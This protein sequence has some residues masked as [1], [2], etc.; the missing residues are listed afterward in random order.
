L[1]RRERNDGGA[2]RSRAG[3]LLLALALSLGAA[4]SAQAQ[5]CSDFGG[6]IDGA[7][8]DVAP[9]QLQVDQNCTIRNFPASS[10]LDTNFSFFTQPGQ[11]P[12]RWL[13]VFDNVVHTGQMSCSSVLNHKIWFTNGSSSSIQEGCQNLLIPVEKIDKQNP[14]GRTTASIGVPFTYRLT[15]PVLFDAGTGTVINDNGSLNDLHGITL[16]DDLNATGA[17]LTYLD[18]VAYWKGSGAPVSHSFSNAGGLLTFGDFPIVPA[19]EQIVVEITVVL[20]DTPTNALGTQFVNTAKWE[21]GRL[22][23]GEFF[24]PLPGEWGVTPPL[25]IAAPALTVTKTGPA[26]L[27]RTLN[28]GEAGTFAIDVQNTGLSEAWDIT[29]LDRLPDGPTGGM[30]DLT[31]ELLSARVFEP[32]GTTPVSGELAPG[33]D[34][35]FAYEG[36]P[37]CELTLTMLTAAG[38]VGPGERL[39]VTY[40]TKLDPDTQDGVSLT[41]V[42]GA[43]RWFNGDDGNPDRQSF[44]RSLTDGTVGV[45]DHE[46]AHTVTA[47][48][49]GYFFEKSVENVTSGQSPA[50]TAA[51]GDTLRYTLRLQTTDVPLDDLIFQDDLGALNASAVFE[52]GTLSLVTVPPGADTS[53]TDPSGG[54]NG[55]G[56]LD[57]RGLS[58]SAQSEIVVQFDVTLDATLADGT[59]VLNQADLISTGKIADSDDPNINGQADPDV[60]GDEDPTRVVIDTTPAGPLL[61]ENTQSTAS[62]GEA[63][64]YRIT[65]PAVPQPFPLYDVRITDDLSTSAA[66]LQF[67]GVTKVSGSQPWTPVH[68]GTATSLVIEDPT[69][70]IDI[71]GGEQI[72]LEISV[73]LEDTPTNVAGLTF[74]NTASFLYNRFDGDPARPV[75]G[76][77]GTSEPMVIVEPEVLTMTKTGPAGMTVGTPET[78]TLDVHNQGS[79]RAWGLTITDRL[80]E[81]SAAGTCDTAPSQLTA[82]V[83][84]ADGVTPVSGPLVEDTDFTVQFTGEPECELTF[85]A[86]TAAASVGS[87]ERLLVTYDAELD[88]NSQNG[89][90]LTNVA[91]ATEWFGSD[92]SNPDT[93]DHRRV[94]TRT[95]TDGTV[96]VLDHEDAHTIESSLPAHAFEKTVVN[97]TTGEDP[98]N[99]AAPG[100]RLRYRL[101]IENGAAGPLEDL[102]LVDELDALNDP[103][104]FEPGTLTLVTVPAGADASN[105]SAT[106]GASGT[107]LVDIRGLDVPADGGSLVVE[108]EVTL[109]AVLTNGRSVA[110]QSRLLINGVD[111]VA[112]DDPNVNGAS[113]PFLEGD[114]DPTRILVESAPE[115]RIEKISTDRTGD[116]D[117]LLA[118]ETL[119]YTITVENVGNG[120]AIDAVLRDAV[121]VNT[122]YVAG[123]TTLNGSP[124]ADGPSGT[125]PLADGIPIASPGEAPGVVLAD[126]SAG[127]AGAATVEFDV[128]VDPGV[129]DGTVISNQ[130]FVSAPDGGI[131][132]RPSDDPGTEVPDDP[133]RD[134][135]G[136]S[137]LL[138]APKTVKILVD[139]GTP[140]IV[141][142]GDVLR[143]TIRIFNTGPV[144]ATGAV[145]TDGVPTNTTYVADSTTLNGLPTARPDGGVFPLAGGVPIASTDQTP[146]LPGPEGGTISPGES[147]VVQFDLLV[148]AGVPG[149]TILRNQALV[150][151]AERPDL[152][153]DGDGNPATGPEPTEVVVGDGQQLAITKQVTVVG[154]GPALAGS[155]VEYVVRVTNIGKVPA[156]DVVLTDDLDAPVA[157]QLTYVAGTAALD[158]STA[159]V[160]VVGPVITADYSGT[161]G[162]L[163]PGASTVLRFRASMDAG[164]TVGTTV[165]NTGVVTW[166]TPPLTASASVSLAVGGM[167]GVGAL[168]G[169]VWHD[170]DFDRTLGGTERVLSDWEVSLYRNGQLV[171]SVL[172][173]ANGTY[174]IAG[175]EP[176]DV[177]GEQYLLRFSAPGAGARSAALGRTESPFT[178]GLQEIADIVLESG[179]NLQGLDLPIDP[180]GVV[181]DAVRRAPIAG[182]RLTM[183]AA[184]SGSPLP[185]SCFDDPAQQDQVTLGDGYYKFDLNFAGASCPSGGDYLIAV[186]APGADFTAGYS[187]I[188]PPTTDD[189]T[190]PFSVPNCPGSVDDAVPATAEHCES[191]PSEFPPAPSVIARSPGT[192]YHVHLSL[193]ASRLSRSSQIFNNHIPLDPVLSEAVS[194]TKTT[195]SVDVSRG[196]LVPY[197]ITFANGLAAELADLGIVDRIPAGFRYVEGSARLD[198]VATE[199]TIDGLELRWTDIGVGASE[200]RS[201]ALLLAVGAG[202]GEGEFV[203]RA[204]AFSSVTGLGL[205]GEATATVRVTPDPTFDCTDVIGK[206][207][208]D[209]DHDGVQAESEEGLQGVRLVTVRGLAATTDAHG[210]FHITCAIVP[211]EERG[212]NFVL[213]LDDR[214]LPSGYRMTTRQVQVQRATRG[215][216]LRFRFGAAIQRVIGLDMADPVFESGSTRIRAHWEPRL[217]LL[218]DELAKQPAILRISYLADVEA[219]DLVERRLRSVKKTIAKAWKTRDGDPLTIETEIFWH[220]GGPPSPAPSPAPSTEPSTRAGPPRAPLE[221]GS[222]ESG[223]PSVDAGPPVVEASSGQTAERHLSRDEPFE[224]WTHDPEL[225]ET[226]SGDR[227]EEQAVVAEE[228]RMVKLTDVVPPIHFESGVADIPL[229]TV[230]RIREV[231]E[232]MRHLENV[233]LHLVGHTDDQALSPALARLYGD[234]EG[235]SRERA[236]EVAEFL[237]Q[238]LDLAPESIS[239]GWA[240]ESR[241]IASN[242]TADGRARNRRVEVEVWYDEIDEKVAVEDIVVRQQIKRVKVCRTQTVC[243][244]RFREG[245]DRRARVRNLI[246]PLHFGEGAVEIPADFLRKIEQ[247]LEDLRDKRNV[248]VKF[249]GFSDD[250]PLT[251]RTERI[252]GTHLALSKARARRVALAVQDALDLPTRAVASDGRGATRPLASNATERGRALN[253]R[254][255]VEVWYDDPLRELP[256]EPQVCPNASTT[257][258]ATKVYE[259]AWGRIPTIEIVDG[260]PVIPAGFPDQVRRA[261]EDVDGRLDVRL[262]FVGYTRNERL[263]RRTAAVYGDDIGLS[264]ARARRAME[265]VRQQLG[266]SE[267]Q[268]EHEGR[269]YVHSKDV[270]NA[271]FIQGETS[272]VVAQVVYDELMPSDDYDGI[273]V[274]PIT[275]EL[276]P[277]HPL[278]LN[279]M[280]ITVDGEPIDDPGRSSADVQRCTDVA[281]ERADIRFRFDDLESDPRLSITADPRSVPIQGAGGKNARAA[282]VRFRTFTNYAHFIDRAEVRIFEQDRSLRAEPLAVVEVAPN[283]T[284]RWQPGT[285][286]FEAPVRKLKFVLRAYDESGRFDETAPQV[287]W[288]VHGDVDEPGPASAETTEDA[289]QGAPPAP[290][291]TLPAAGDPLLDGYGESD[292]IARSIPLGSTGTVRVQGS[293][294]PPG[295]SVWVAGTPVPV[296]EGGR[297][298]AEAVLPTGLH[299]V[300]VAVLDESGSGELFLRDLE[301]EKNDWFYVGM[302]DLTF[303]ADLSGGR[304]KELEGS[305]SL[306]DDDSRVDGRLAYYLTGK[307]GKDWR[308]TSSADTREG[309]IDELFTNFLDK[310]PESLFRR[311][312][313]DRHFPT[314]GDDG[315]VEENAPTLGKFYLKLSKGESHLLWGNFK[316][317]YSDNELALVERGLYGANLHYQ[318]PS[319]TR[320]GEQRVVIDGFAADPGTVNNREEFRGT[321]GSLY[322]LQ[323][324]DL[325]M[326]SERIRIEVR[327]K[328]SGLVSEVVSLQPDIDYDIDYLQGRVLLSE[329]ISSTVRDD[330]LVRDDGLSGNE[331]WLVV[332]YEYTPGFDEIDTLTAGGQ[333]HFWL[334]DFVRLGATASRNEEDG[335]SSSLYAADLTVRRSAR[336]WLK[337][338]AGRSEGLVSTSL[339]SDD[340]G[341]S[342]VEPVGLGLARKDAFGYRADLSIDFADLG[343]GL[344]GTLDLYGQLLEGGYSA[345]GLNT[346]TDTVQYGVSLKLP[347]RWGLEIAA[348]ADRTIQED[349]LE[350]TAAELDVEYR[351]TDSWSVSLGARHDERE[352][353]SPVVPAT[354]EVGDRTDAVVQV[355][356]DSEA[357][358]RTYGFAQTTVRATGNRENNQRVGLGGAL[359]LTDRLSLDGE[360]SHGDIGP[361][362]KAGTSYQLS[363]ATKMYMNYSLDNERGYDGLHTRRG[364][365]TVGSRSRMSDSASV[366]LENRYEHYAVEGLT[367]AVGVT[368]TP[369]ERWNLGF[370]WESGVTSDQQTNAETTRRSGGA[371]LAYRFDGALVSTAVEYIFADTEDLDGTKSERTTWLFKNTVQWQIDPDWRLIGKFNHAI[372]DSSRG[373]FFDG[374]FSEA[375]L[376]YAYRPVSHD[377]LHVL[378]KFTYFYNVPSTDQLS[379]QGTP[380]HFVQKSYVGALDVT[381][382]LTDSW[383]IGGKYA[384]RRGEVS[385]DREDP[386][387]FNNDAHLYILRADWRFRRAWEATVEGRM[388]DLDE[389]KAGA[390]V[391]LYR[392]LGEHFKVG[393]AYNFTDF[394]EDLTDLSFEH[395]GIFFNIVGTL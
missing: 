63:F 174:A 279:L 149:G 360:V 17:D 163:P 157:G 180:N 168:S 385:L 19:G 259:P 176:N 147:A 44:T 170:A 364:Q 138:F 392:Y 242:A 121:P 351:V 178:D 84:Q 148:D 90:A 192:S 394:S 206:V 93:A 256:D 209:A 368:L 152:L 199:P 118:G 382:D 131:S 167:P 290:D 254:V 335:A 285:E 362:A 62:V 208:D 284:A 66:D 82:R 195:P 391:A 342:F 22:I 245:H 72:V 150:S 194:I 386:D 354:Q 46:D 314:F 165:T 136:S 36:A 270:V 291:Q 155:Q 120:H 122:T 34:F 70:G 343:E 79:G 243:K 164:L 83:V 10:P 97:L 358:W 288:L 159:G 25:T 58:A 51:P 109:A 161:H 348:Q 151:S 266:L 388:L 372:S 387:F 39:I 182:A 241:P 300:E 377:R 28:L 255:E 331:L 349:G 383:S 143:Y 172:T 201:L 333:A 379:R 327:D 330:L 186:T 190:S 196:D 89:I 369:T 127:G 129:L 173:A 6:L 96:G 78:F 393:I 139:G 3:I 169:T 218:L 77:P 249:I 116:P 181:Y 177:N 239:F 38:V 67:L 356:Y 274:T 220:R 13:I 41:N 224:Q 100:D 200:R 275:R 81:T 162:A 14:A 328:V 302:A 261:M 11:N 33:T 95:L 277:R 1:V 175:L 237:Q 299:T 205:S 75:S 212:S 235:L 74:T 47:A 283:G 52:P 357:R 322:L 323:R 337:L 197:E 128:V 215:K 123:S 309:P 130:A 207:F 361:S 160:S 265:R 250:V 298:V 347:L 338:Q 103:P 271:G 8:G 106:G 117:L 32:D 179:S 378:G 319:T 54:T 144:A 384:Y 370:D 296:D 2:G 71:P 297:F 20:E 119:R 30:C 359:R 244:L 31:P 50:A 76:D 225:L 21:F 281:L 260:E 198:G 154:G 57:I 40:E 280:R 365:L 352:D 213:K 185:S 42:A 68:T 258:R 125:S 55:A 366:Y 211:H 124:V 294:I 53:N 49:F 69:D 29:I 376:G 110:N 92:G 191:Q 73:V 105:T 246:E 341:F 204:Q 153:T 278:A 336:T 355:A 142:P 390:L 43:T 102:T 380:I 223:L 227:L 232:G 158:G 27:G 146:P 98:A 282:A 111:F 221:T 113:D 112:S 340:G 187:T 262:R 233:R 310:S 85:T 295:H 315:K 141:D 228:A 203:N 240:G 132:D 45:L 251:G 210:R 308:L 312:D 395:H 188:I 24:E 276:E 389:R 253:R 214:T 326:G 264:T 5:D 345:P 350:N 306:T 234:N 12:D 248:T 273:E 381:Y 373:D 16:T 65:V 216:A 87:D 375:V 303:S 313:P 99:R 269:G 230:E 305:D 346:L 317:G 26:T 371:R 286:A 311:I 183:L 363:E 23:D 268:V 18:H 145:L 59:V 217:D 171:R 108:F 126:P 324:Q 231:L 35:S 140:D 292:A 184:G 257:E 60:A 318:S 61:K 367:R 236:G 166:S 48:L 287:L 115:F 91:G 374:G 332:Q 156:L 339:R 80:A 104:A 293:D 272:H 64:R 229:S 137:P 238:A 222:T 329:P 334:N 247:A 304:P 9:S 94:Y 193:D 86:L 316:V 263:D 325:L 320:F 134:V 56:R 301:L 4:A 101:R 189:S 226:Q 219:P 135:V 353:D 321:G 107:G 114:E 267:S 307:F 344:N 252:Y 88:V 15:I 37:A 202:V 289:E 7:A 133:T